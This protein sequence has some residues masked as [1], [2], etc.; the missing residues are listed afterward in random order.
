MRQWQFRA[1][2]VAWIVRPTLIYL[3][4]ILLVAVL[5]VTESDIWLPALYLVG[6]IA[7]FAAWKSI[8]WPDNWL[9]YMSFGAFSFWS[10]C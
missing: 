10:V 1:R 3:L 5:K 7:A 2:D 6:G 9:K 8:R 4:G